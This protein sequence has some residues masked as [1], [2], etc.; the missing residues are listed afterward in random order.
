MS[1][2]VNNFKFEYSNGCCSHSKQHG[3][4]GLITQTRYVYASHNCREV[5]ACDNSEGGQLHKTFEANTQQKNS[6][7]GG[8]RSLGLQAIGR[9]T[10][11]GLT[12]LFRVPWSWSRLG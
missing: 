2:E 6:C 3:H 8:A 5:Y 9:H 7:L 12:L 11:G 1:I 4:L 10:K